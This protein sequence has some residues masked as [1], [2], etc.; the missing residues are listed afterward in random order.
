L[1]IITGT[2]VAILVLSFLAAMVGGFPERL[3]LIVISSFGIVTVGTIISWQLNEK[4][5][6]SIIQ[7]EIREGIKR[8]EL[9]G[10]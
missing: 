8:D 2:F 7:R 5:F 9:E 10:Y 6:K 3:K 1:Y 4:K